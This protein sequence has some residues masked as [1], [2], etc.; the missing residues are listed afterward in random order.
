M[1]RTATVWSASLLIVAAA[2]YVLVRI[3]V[4]LAPLT[5]AL[6]ATLFLAALLDPIQL[7]LRRLRFPGALAALTSL[8]VLLGFLAGSAVVVW[9][10]AGNEF[11]T[12]DERLGAGLEQLREFALTT[13]PIT[14]EQLD[15][16]IADALAA[17]R[18]EPPDPLESARA[19][20]E[21][22]GAV[23]L[24]IVLLFFLLKDGRSMWRWLA[25]RASSHLQPTLISA[26]RAGWQTL[27]AYSRGTLTIAAI[28]ATGIGLALFF[29]DVPAPV[30]LALI[31]FLGAFVPIIGATVAGVAAIL[32]AL[33]AEGPTTALLTA[34]AVIGVQQMEGNLLEPLIMKRQVRLHPAV[35]LVV[36][37]AG[38]LAGGVP[39]AFVAVPITAVVYRIV[40]TVSAYRVEQPPDADAATG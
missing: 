25:A 24:S 9:R 5:I 32:V 1:I 20:M 27:T 39:G 7:G 35:V 4:G 37:T 31:T 16:W 10:L 26:G 28:D 38:A 14:A 21:V 6:A 19:A 3:A 34:L 12:L 29:L 11:A 2:L 22:T 33:A 18:R 23:L 36:V 13:L 30:P 40:E 15:A 8:L 17:L